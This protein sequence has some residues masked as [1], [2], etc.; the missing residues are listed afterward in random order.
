MTKDKISPHN[1]IMVEKVIEILSPQDGMVYIDGTFGAGGH[2][3]AILQSANCLVH[4]FDRDITTAQYAEEIS[5]NF[6]DKTL[7]WHNNKFSEMHEIMIKYWEENRENTKHVAGI[8][9]DIGVSSMQLNQA[10][11][12]FS[13]MNEGPLLMTMG[14]NTTTAYELIHELSEDELA[15][16]ITKY[17]EEPKAREIAKAIA[18]HRK[19][20]KINTTK[21]L[22]DL[23]SGT[24]GPKVAKIHPATLT[25]QALRIMVNDE[26]TE[27][28][29][30]II[31]AS[32]LLDIGGTLVIISFQ[33]LENIVIKNCFRRLIRGRNSDFAGF[34]QESS[35][36]QD[37]NNTFIKL[38]GGKAI[39]P[40]YKEIKRNPRARSALLRAIQRV[41]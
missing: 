41:E 14:N 15:L 10:D 20:K 28:E 17:G 26:L 25:F 31:A 34:N 40:H 36:S 7:L 37:Q 21:E 5:K 30:G 9:L 22:A 27:L 11:R 2:T 13:F 4:A 1:P 6:C 18:K 8:L 35:G 3:K 29:N 39:K 33:G 24:V 16:V 23:I 38:Y 19:H 32:K 12:G